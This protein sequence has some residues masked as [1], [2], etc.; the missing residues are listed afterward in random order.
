MPISQIPA[1]LHYLLYYPPPSP[2]SPLS[3]RKKTSFKV[4]SLEL[5]MVYTLTLIDRQSQCNYESS[6]IIKNN[7]LILQAKNLSNQSKIQNIAC[8]ALYSKPGSKKKSLLLDHISESFS[9]LSKKFGQ[10][11]HF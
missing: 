8:F 5:L 6:Y 3:P 1:K 9:I 4:M 11:L 10:G 2:C 7:G